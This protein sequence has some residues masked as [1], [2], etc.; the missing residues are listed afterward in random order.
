MV[1]F[2]DP[3]KMRLLEPLRHQ[4]ARFVALDMQGVSAEAEEEFGDGFRGRVAALRNEVWKQRRWN[5]S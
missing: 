2:L 4:R 3:D 1:V 5:W